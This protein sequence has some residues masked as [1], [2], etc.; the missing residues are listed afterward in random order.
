[1]AKF[2]VGDQVRLINGLPLE[3]ANRDIAERTQGQILEITPEGY[4]VQF[5]DN[6]TAIEGI[7]ENEIEADT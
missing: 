5:I 6:K 7:T 1:M 4:V 3:K 2:Q